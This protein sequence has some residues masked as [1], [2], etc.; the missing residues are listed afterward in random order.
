MADKNIPISAIETAIET[1]L[2]EAPDGKFTMAEL[3]KAI[4]AGKS[5]TLQGRVERTVDG[6]GRFFSDGKGNFQLRS[7]FFRNR[8]FLITPDAWEIENDMLFPGHRFAPF[9]NP[10]I[11]PSEVKLIDAD[12]QPVPKKEVTAPL[13]QVFHYHLLLGSEQVFDFFVADSP[14]NSR[15]RNSAQ[16]GDMVTLNTFDLSVFFKKHRFSVG[17]ALLCKVVDYEDGI[18]EFR[19][20]SGE[21]RQ[22][23]KLKAYVEAFE[24]ALGIVFD[25]FENYLEIPEQLSWA[26]YAG[27]ATL[28]AAADS[29]SDDEFLRRASGIEINFDQE[30]TVLARKS[31]APEDA[32]ADLPEGVTFSR[33]ETGDIAALLREIGSPLT[34]VEIDSFILDNCHARELE[35]EDF[36]ARAFGR[37]KLNFTDEGQQAVFYNYIE[38]RFEELTGEYNRYDDEPKAPL[39][40]T[41]MELVEDRLNFFDFL[42]NENASP[43][44]LPHD[45][46]HRLAE[47]AMQLNEILKL[48]NNP[49]FTPDNAELDRLTETVELRADD[50]DAL[51]GRLTD[52]FADGGCGH[53]HHGDDCDCGCCHHK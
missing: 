10:E 2:A 41:V 44:Q 33:G 48:L 28:P 31:E 3:L 40:S 8:E 1:V 53:D 43:E 37:E 45:E 36:F 35:F 30:H 7:E 50:Q 29:A 26:H 27:R 32:A 15:I 5:Q 4:S 19:Y 34:P 39:R 21:N 9:V 16:P 24:A 38:D 14:A 42:S 20:L 17:D 18:I 49:G 6:D 23:S 51:I 25:R 12:G 13:S 11:F 47:I 22:D 46:M 52:R